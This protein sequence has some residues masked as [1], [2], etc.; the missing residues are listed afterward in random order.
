MLTEYFGKPPSDMMDADQS[1][2]FGATVMAGLC[3][4][5]DVIVRPNP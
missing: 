3:C 1:V 5:E 4:G 2:A